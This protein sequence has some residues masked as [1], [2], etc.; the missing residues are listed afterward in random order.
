LPKVARIVG[1]KSIVFD[2]QGRHIQDL[3]MEISERYGQEIRTFL[4]DESGQLDTVFKIQ[5]NKTQWISRDRLD[6]PLREGDRVTFM[7][8]VGGG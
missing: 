6:T 1:N 3:I 8:L 7:M 2:L 4:L 5:L